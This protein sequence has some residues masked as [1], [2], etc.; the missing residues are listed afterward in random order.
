M[1]QENI[2]WSKLSKWQ[3][4][5]ME[6]ALQMQ[7]EFGHALPGNSFTMI[8]CRGILRKVNSR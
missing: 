2:P 8:V 7:R 1:S 4:D 5:W 6:H 3:R